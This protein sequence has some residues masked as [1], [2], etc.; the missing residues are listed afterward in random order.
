MARTA[1]QADPQLIALAL[2][3]IA[4]TVLIARLHVRAALGLHGLSEYA[5][6]AEIITSELVTTAIQHACGNRTATVGAALTA[7]A[8]PAAVTIAV[9]DFSP[10]GLI[11]REPPP[12][13]EQGRELQ[14]VHALS[15][16]CGWR[17][18]D[19]GKAVFAVLAREA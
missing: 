10:H 18:Q 2:P 5:D 8:S 7:A 9:S 19:G 4:E 14:I 13:S 17:R 15:A 12:G 6:D 1:T 3:G 16:R 11:R